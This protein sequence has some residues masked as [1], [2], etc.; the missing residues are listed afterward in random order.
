MRV[1]LVPDDVLYMRTT[2]VKWNIAGLYGP[3]AELHF[4]LMK[5]D[6]KKGPVPPQEMLS[7]RYEHGQLI[8]FDRDACSSCF[9]PAV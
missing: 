3:F 4:F 6:A 2:A 9:N 1:F 5:K 8:G 7:V